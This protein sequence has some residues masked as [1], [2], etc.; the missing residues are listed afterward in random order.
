MPLFYKILIANA[1]IVIAAA[2]VASATTAQYV[3][4]APMYSTLELVTLLAAGGVLV[5][6]L[7]NALILRVA[8][9]PL[10]LLGET[11]N[12]VEQGELDAHAPYSPVA[13][14]E[15][16]HLTWTFN[17]M[18]DSLAM[19]RRRLREIA[20]R[21]LNAEEAERKRIAR[22]LHD[23]TAQ[24]LAALLIRLRLARAATDPEKQ[25]AML[26]AL[27][28]E[29]SE[30]LEGVRRF[31]RGLRPPA[32]DELGLVAAIESHVRMLQQAS[33]LEV[34]I[35]ADPLGDVLTPE[36][37]LALYRI[38]QEA[39]SNALRHAGATRATVT[40][41]RERGHVSA[42][43]EDN[44]CGFSVAEVMAGPGRGL[45][46]FG[47]KERAGYVG[48]QFEIR[49]EPG[50]GTRVEIEVPYTAVP[51]AVNQ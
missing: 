13:D 10:A 5:S 43:V 35:D 40:I 29:L 12:R 6:V 47:M 33:A 38:V 42:R 20:A 31:A 46:L 27:R 22:E 51:M 2:I 44:G 45:G 39:L 9:S 11:A 41:R 26:D 4:S 16:V 18:L 30:A 19:Y 25:G 3:R 7:V 17:R 21:S 15:L 37:E 8:L 23:E 14:R 32:L 1:L 48:G 24:T 49:S 28:L 36:A 50:H 34:A